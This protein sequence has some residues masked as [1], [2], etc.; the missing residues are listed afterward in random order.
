MKLIKIVKK[1]C[2]AGALIASMAFNTNAIGAESEPLWTNI[3]SKGELR[4]GAAVAPP[5]VIRNPKTGEYSGVYVDLCK[6]FAEKHLGVKAKFVDTTW[7]NIIAGLQAGKW[8]ISL[9][10]NRKPKRAMAVTF[11]ASAMFSEASFVFNGDNPKLKD[12][13]GK[14]SS[15]DKK[16]ITIAVMSGTVQEQ[17]LSEVIK[18]AKILRLPGNDETRLALISRRADVLA[19]MADTNRIFSANNS[20]WAKTELPAPA[21]LKQGIAN[22]LR[23]NVAWSDV[24]VF[25]IYLEEKVAKGEVERLA[26]FYTEKAIAEAK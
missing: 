19:D 17:A 15:F 20:E 24:E 8:D 14:L 7:D 1:T 13:D 26:Q 4:C 16:G 23:K 18:N 3:Q 9:A 21:L 5:Y 25:N 6:E 22:G 10:L 12:A 11:S 2:Y